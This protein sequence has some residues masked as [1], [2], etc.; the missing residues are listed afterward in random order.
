MTTTGLWQRAYV[1]Y[2]SIDIIDQLCTK[3]WSLPIMNFSVRVHPLNLSSA[4]MKERN[5]YTLKLSGLSKGSIQLDLDFIIQDTNAKSYYI[6]RSA[7]SF[8]ICHLPPRYSLV[9]FTPLYRRPT[10][11]RP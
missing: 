5:A 7:I 3:V 11:R 2:N 10:P 6:P 4:D 8:V 1:I 9:P